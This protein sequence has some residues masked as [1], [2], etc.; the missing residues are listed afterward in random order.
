[1]LELANLQIYHGLELN[2]GFTYLLCWP[3]DEDRLVL[4]IFYAG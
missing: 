1:M 4:H 3:E 2:S